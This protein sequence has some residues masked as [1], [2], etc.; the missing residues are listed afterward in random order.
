[1][2]EKKE[3]NSEKKRQFAVQLLIA[4][5]IWA[6]VRDVVTWLDGCFFEY[7]PQNILGSDVDVVFEV[8][9]PDTGCTISPG[10]ELPEPKIKQEKKGI[11]AWLELP[12]EEKA[13]ALKLLQDL[14]TTIVKRR[15]EI[16]S[17][18]EGLSELR[19]LL[20]LVEKLGG[21]EALQELL[22]F[23]GD[24]PQPWEEGD[25]GPA[26][27]AVIL[28]KKYEEKFVALRELLHGYP[29]AEAPPLP[30]ATAAKIKELLSWPVPHLTRVQEA[31]GASR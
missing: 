25:P 15:P 7:S 22:N 23:F 14:P 20:Q 18:F 5:P 9:C 31:A 10:V 12:K 6:S 24:W 11:A 29:I 1:M 3:N 19:E 2:A 21:R 8:K 16:V 4:T 27:R 17:A 28:V 26:R 30:G 13:C